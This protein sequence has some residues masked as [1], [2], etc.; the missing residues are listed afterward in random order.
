MAALTIIAAQLFTAGQY[1]LA[2]RYKQADKTGASIA[3]FRDDMITIKKEADATM[4]ALDKVVATAPTD[5]RKAFKANSHKAVPRID[6]AAKKAK[7]RS[8]DMKARGQAYFKEWEKELEKA[9]QSDNS[10]AG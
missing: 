1:I 10:K 6:D 2:A 9:E 4:A 8:V 7:K 5:P 3:E